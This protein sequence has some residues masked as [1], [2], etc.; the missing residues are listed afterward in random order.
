MLCAVFEAYDNKE[1]VEMAKR[2]RKLNLIVSDQKNPIG[3]AKPGS[4]LEVVAVALTG[5]KA[6]SKQRIG[7]RLCGG[8]STCLAL[9]DVEKGGSA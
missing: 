3:S 7:A 4:T 5:G 1:G 6:S 2:G 9:V 8:T